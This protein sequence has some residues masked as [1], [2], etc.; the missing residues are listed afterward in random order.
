M[1]D[2]FKFASLASAL[3]R[4][5]IFGERSALFARLQQLGLPIPEARILSFNAVSLG[6]VLEEM[7]FSGLVALRAS[8]ERREWGGSPALLHLG[9]CEAALASLQDDIGTV[10]ALGLYRRAI[11]TYGTRIH[12]LD[13]EPFETLLYDHSVHETTPSPA[14]MERLVAE[15]L[16]LF[17]AEAGTAFPQDPA[18]QLR[19]AIETFRDEWSSPRAAILRRARG[20]P[21]KARLGLIVQRMVIP[22]PTEGRGDAGSGF[23]QSV[24]DVTGKA[25]I[26]GTFLPAP[27]P[28]GWKRG[29][30]TARFITSAERAEARDEALSL[31][32]CAPEAFTTL[33]DATAEAESRLGE[34]FNVAYLVDRGRAWVFDMVPTQRSAPAAVQ[35]VVDLARERLITRDEALLRIDPPRL[36]ECLHPRLD[37]NARRDLLG[38]GLPASPGAATGRI[39]FSAMAAMSAAAQDLQAILVRPETSP[40]DIRGIYAAQGVLTLRGGMTSHAAVIARGLGVPCIVGAGELKLDGQ[41][42]VS[43]DGRRW[44]EGDTITLDGSTGEVLAGAPRMIRADMTPAFTTFLGWADE[45]RQLGVRANA[46]TPHEARLARNF[47]VD[48]IGLCRTEHMFFENGRINVMREMI[49]AEGPEDRLKALNRLLP[50]QRADFEELFEIMEGL[51][52]TIRLLDPPLHE[53]LPSDDADLASLAKAMDLPVE[54]VKARARALAEFN[55][56]L[57]MRGVRLGITMPEIY[58]MQARA[59]FEAAIAAGRKT[60]AEISPEIMIPLVSANRESELVKSRLDA[61]AKAVAEETGVDFNYK[62]GVMVETPRG[63]LRAGDLARTS[64]FLSFGTNDLTQ[65]TYGLS[66]DDAGRFMRDYVNLQVFREDPFRSLDLEGVGELVALG[67]ARGRASNPDLE[68]GLCGEHGGDPASIRFCAREG[69]D[70]VSCSAYRVPIARLAAAQSALVA[71]K[72]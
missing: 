51:P 54:Q 29:A 72:K 21:E 4:P 47:K 57:G 19:A 8:P 10:A 69:F 35:I 7:P 68:I 49:L 62:T 43:P 48:G 64:A 66:R 17:E 37:P 25:G 61:V 1:G 46:D 33:R 65:M 22:T 39:V 60:G 70:Y 12:D 11:Q 42:L 58:D 41:S 53:F 20:A 40:E 32:D 6:E 28:G 44:S 31:Q 63:A 16:A 5:G 14:T 71:L 67:A 36:A 13:A 15:T 9:M 38:T 59:I 27:P 45:V 18:T 30:E 34:R 26:T 23:F 2:H 55:P 50:M 56:M 24:D 52:V 3:D